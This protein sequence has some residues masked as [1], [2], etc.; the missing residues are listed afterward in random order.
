MGVA[1]G[2]LQFPAFAAAS[3]WFDKKRAAAM[4]IVVSGSSIGG[5]VIPIAV[6]KMLNSSSLGFG[7]TVRIIGFLII[8]LMAFSSV[9]VKARLPPR[10]SNFFIL[11]AFKD[12]KYILLIASCFFGFIGMFAPLFFLPTYAVYRGMNPTLA[13][14][15]LAI[16]NAASTFGRIIPGILADKYGRLNMFSI[17]AISTGIIIF[18]MN[19]PKSDAGI[20]VYS[21]VIGF[22]S[23]TIISGASAAFSLCVKDVREMGT[24]MGMGLGIAAISVLIGPPVNGVLVA[25]TNGFFKVSMFSGSLTVFGGLLALATKMATPEGIF[26]KI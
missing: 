11:S 15:M 17:G 24:Y 23:G 3:Q 7:W 18:F 22:S 6:S 10:K 14:Y 21:I 13:G 19:F 4:G 8:P 2:I 9:S 20:I 5:V 1:M 16:L 12:R 25:E 26:G